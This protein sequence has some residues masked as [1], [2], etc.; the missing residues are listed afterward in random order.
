MAH[1]LQVL[2]LEQ[3]RAA[4]LIAQPPRHLQRRFYLCG[5]LA[6][7]GRGTPRVS[8]WQPLLEAELGCPQSGRQ[9]ESIPAKAVARCCQCYNS[10]FLCWAPG[11]Q[12]AFT[13]E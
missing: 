2:A 8:Q 4:Q 12:V 5:S 3:Q 6:S 13:F 10:V 11:K 9:R 7:D 1:G